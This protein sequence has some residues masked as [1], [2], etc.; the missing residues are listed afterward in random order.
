MCLSGAESRFRV[1][2]SERSR[3]IWPAIAGTLPF[4]TRFLHYLMLRITP[5]GMT[6]S[7][8]SFFSERSTCFLGAV[9]PLCGW[10]REACLNPGWQPLSER[11]ERSG[12]C[13][14]AHPLH[15]LRSFSGCRPGAKRSVCF[16]GAK[17][18]NLADNCTGSSAR[19]RIPPL[20]DAAHHFGRNDSMQPCLFR[21]AQRVAGKGLGQEE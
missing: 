21:Y 12:W 10:C 3:G 5:V 13:L 9:E 8:L 7:G 15:S 14:I 4:E 11:S 16:L 18:R 1:R 6:T 2:H 19:S 17:S 20:S